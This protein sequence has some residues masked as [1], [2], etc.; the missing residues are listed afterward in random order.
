MTSIYIK[1][2]DKTLEKIKF[3]NVLEELYYKLGVIDDSKYSMDEL[4]DIKKLL[5]KSDNFI[6]LF[7]IYSKNF[8]LIN[9]DNVY[10]R[11][12][13]FHYRLPS[14]KI[15]IKLKNTL[16]E[17]DDKSLDHYKEKLQK[18]INFIDNFDMNILEKNY[19]RLFYLSQP[20]NFEITSCQKPS[21]IPFI[22]QK[23]YYT[24]SELI[25]LGL[26]MGIDLDDDIE[27]ICKQ[28]S[29]NDITA[30][31][32]LNHQI[33]IKNTAKSYI[34]LYTLLGSYYWNFYIRNECIRDIYV[35]KQIKILYN[36]IKDA[37]KLD[38]DYWVYR[39]V[40]NDEYLNHLKVNDIFDEQSFISTTRNP[41][42][43]TKNNTFGFIL[44]KILLPKAK[45][46]V[47]LCIESYSLFPNEEEIL[48]NPSKLK[49][50]AIENNFKYY[51]PNKNAAKKIKKMYI[52]EYISSL[53]LS[54]S[55]HYQTND[56]KIPTISWLD[57]VISGD[58]FAS[59]VYYF[60]RSVLPLFNNKRYFYSK[61]GNMKYLFQA[62]YLD[63]NPIYEKYFFLQNKNNFKQRDQI[64]FILQ[65]EKTGEIYLIIELRD[66]ISV[67]YIHKFIGAKNIFTDEEL[68]KF[69]SSVAHY[70][71]ISEVMIHNVH[72]S[73]KSISEKMLLNYDS[74]VFKQSNPDNHLISLYSGDFKYYDKDLI[75][76]IENKKKRFFG[77]AGI[78]YTVK[79]HQIKRFSKIDAIKLF[80]NVEKSPL[81]NIVLKKNKQSNINILDFYIYIHYN[82]FYLIPELNK[83][84]VK[85]DKD[86]FNDVEN[87]P[88]INSYVILNSEEYLY[89][90]KLI[91]HI[92]IFSSNIYQDYLTKLGAEHKNMS[93]NKYR[94]GLAH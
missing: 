60:Y 52:F 40:D 2:P 27:N 91:T 8:Y 7:D 44:I 68:I 71:G 35:E 64:Y 67:N 80:D 6:P 24:K 90:N 12:I 29:N 43:D 9:S 66:T 72:Q 31:T 94:L 11:V 70:F 89:E 46:G 26:N 23:P 4:K 92:K 3:E 34:Q 76:M 19:Y 88:W 37:P 14:E 93:F 30:N 65:D 36:I 48:L 63:D 85:F 54:S 59:K 83:L 62:F 84:I 20:S 50:K 41:F 56:E 81:Y 5:S 32:I 49:L 33:Y 74:N 55:E 28:V 77:L 21:F 1:Y 16:E 87:S 86:I 38:K 51:H 13:N 58:D 25:N 57:A 22:A 39:F 82:Y 42:Y 10:N 73:Y 53:P 79:N 17:I 69:L 18:N 45:K 78:T 15:V 75:D 47:G 61:I